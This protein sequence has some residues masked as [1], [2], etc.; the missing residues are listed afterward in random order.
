MWKSLSTS[1]D[2]LG[3]TLGKNWC[4]TH[5]ERK[6]LG[7]EWSEATWVQKVW[8]LLFMDKHW[9]FRIECVWFF[10]VFPIVHLHSH[11]I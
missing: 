11:S 5:L 10:H 7:F 3:I 4:W 6:I 8:F 9:K 2:A 1:C